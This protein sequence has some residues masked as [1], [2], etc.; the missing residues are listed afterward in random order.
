M[1]AR[2]RQYE[3]RQSLKKCALMGSNLCLVNDGVGLIRIYGKN[4]LLAGNPLLFCT[5]TRCLYSAGNNDLGAAFVEGQ[6][7]EQQCLTQLFEVPSM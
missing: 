3:L 2:A 7:L 6:V 4:S 1:A 5:Q